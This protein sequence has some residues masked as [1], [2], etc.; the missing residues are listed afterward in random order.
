MSGG[1]RRFRNA[2]KL[3]GLPHHKTLEEFD[4]T[5]QPDLGARKVRHPATMEFNLSFCDLK[6]EASV[7]ARFAI[8]LNISFKQPCQSLWC[9]AGAGVLDGQSWAGPNGDRHG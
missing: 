2:L 9:D 4:F 6:T 1:G 3:S 7:T 8:S 5:F